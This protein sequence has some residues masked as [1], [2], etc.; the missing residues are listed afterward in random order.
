MNIIA[1]VLQP[2]QK[3]NCTVIMHKET[4]LMVVQVTDATELNPGSA[5]LYWK[6]QKLHYAYL[7]I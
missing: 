7:C 2:S 5:L 3:D 4:N 6:D 1:A